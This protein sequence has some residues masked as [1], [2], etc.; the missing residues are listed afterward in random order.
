MEWATAQAVAHVVDLTIAIHEGHQ[1]KGFGKALLTHLIDWAKA[2]PNVEKIML[3]VRSS[4]TPA[5]ALYEKMGF[6]VEGVRVKM[7]KLTPDSYVDNIAMALWV[8]T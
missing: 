5:V 2:N 7:I 1:G 4:N 3:H 6:I 8:G